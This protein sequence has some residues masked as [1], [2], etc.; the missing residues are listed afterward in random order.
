V[1]DVTDEDGVFVVRMR[2][3]PVNAL[4]MP[5][6]E[7]LDAALDEFAARSGRV[8][9]IGSAVP[10]FFAAGADIKKM[11]GCDLEEFTAYGRALRAVVERVARLDRPSIAAVEGRALGGGMELALAATIR[12]GSGAARFGLPE[13]KIGLIPSAGAT[14]RLP[15]F[16]GRGRALELMLSGREFDA[17]EAHLVGVVDRL[18]PAGQAESE[19]I[20]LAHQLSVLSLPA[21]RDIMRGVDDAQE[22]PLDAGLVR[23]AA[24]VDVLFT[25]PDAQEGLRAFVDK[26]TPKFA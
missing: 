23:E 2:R 24:R 20:A 8:L 10:G 14:Q 25:G 21:L 11:V 15:R 12:V 7:S 17:D 16:V 13:A 18:V 26:R 19:A 5:L 1:V 4:G 22:L 6:I 3:P 9:V